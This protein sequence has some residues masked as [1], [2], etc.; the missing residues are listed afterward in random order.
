M[1]ACCWWCLFSVSSSSIPKT[2]LRLILPALLGRKAR[3]DLNCGDHYQVMREIKVD[4][5]AWGEENMP[6]EIVW[7]PGKSSSQLVIALQ[8]VVQTGCA[9]IA[10]RVPDQVGIIP[11]LPPSFFE[12]A[13]SPKLR[14]SEGRCRKQPLWSYTW[15]GLTPL[16]GLMFCFSL[17]R[18]H[19]PL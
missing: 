7:A 5:K 16:E 4:E 13:Y 6:A 9:A 14:T 8:R 2:L 19:W 11:P 15:S 10:V 18:F 1:R 12:N 17:C 3:D